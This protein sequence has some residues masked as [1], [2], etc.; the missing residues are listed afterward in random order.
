MATGDITSSAE[1]PQGILGYPDKVEVSL[2]E[3][4]P[5]RKS[6]AYYKISP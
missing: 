2:E 4:V 3:V 1:P 6:E 5:S